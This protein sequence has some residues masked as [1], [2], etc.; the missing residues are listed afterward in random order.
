VFDRVR[1]YTNMFKTD[2]FSEVVNRSINATLSRT[3]VTSG[4]TLLVVLTLF[5]FGGEVLRG[6]AFALILGVVIGTYSSI[7]V[8]SPVVVE[9]RAREVRRVA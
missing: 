8:A 7:F 6:F 3:V 4:T 2:R 1:E 5:I 9:L